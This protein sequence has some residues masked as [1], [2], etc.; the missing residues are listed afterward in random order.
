MRK[1]VLIIIML[2]LLSS[3]LM[4]GSKGLFHTD[5]SSEFNKVAT[6]INFLGDTYTSQYV[7]FQDMRISPV[8]QCEQWNEIPFEAT[9]QTP[10]DQIVPDFNKIAKFNNKGDLIVM[11]AVNVSLTAEML[12]AIEKP[13]LIICLESKLYSGNFPT[14]FSKNQNDKVINA[15]SGLLKATSFTPQIKKLIDKGVKTVGGKHW[16]TNVRLDSDGR[17]MLTGYAFDLKMVTNLGESLLNSGA[18]TEIHINSLTKNVYEKVPVWR[19]DMSGKV[20]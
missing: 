16:V 12:K 17:I 19:F 8:I 15:F 1:I 4:A 11:Q 5:G 3:P 14:D 18:F 2:F 9:I 7:R 20:K 13:L 10:E 6:A